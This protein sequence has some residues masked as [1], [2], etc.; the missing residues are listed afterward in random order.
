M[1]MRR[2]R[3]LSLA[4]SFALLAA[5]HSAKELPSAEP[6]PA[7]SPP[8]E[9]PKAAPPTG[10]LHLGE[11]ITATNVVSLSDITKS[12]KQ[13]EGQVV[14]TTGT[15]FAVCQSMGCWMEIKDDKN[16]E[17]HVKL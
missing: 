4:A 10:A 3:A 9:A 11:P 5:C 8:A 14:T 13:Y 7:S 15:V 12:P 17:A 6:A 16:T 2:A 1:A